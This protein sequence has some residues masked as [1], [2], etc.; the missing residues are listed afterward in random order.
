MRWAPSS[1][2]WSTS[3]TLALALTAGPAALAQSQRLIPTPFPET[4][5]GNAAPL[6]PR[7]FTGRWHQRL[8]ADPYPQTLGANAQGNPPITRR[9]RHQQLV[10][11]IRKREYRVDW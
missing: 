8:N 2:R 7:P 1:K 11:N 9:V 6:D 10:P 3:L 4:L 5:G